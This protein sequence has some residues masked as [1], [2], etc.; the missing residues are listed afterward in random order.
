MFMR[1]VCAALQ[2][3]AVRAGGQKSSPLILFLPSPLFWPQS[4]F[5]LSVLQA[6]RPGSLLQHILRKEAR[7]C[8]VVLSP[9]NRSYFRGAAEGSSGRTESTS[10]SP[11]LISSTCSL[12][13]IQLLSSSWATMRKQ[14]DEFTCLKNIWV[15]VN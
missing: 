4:N 2:Q 10:S 1:C 14:T 9:S 3:A 11:L 6:M 7:N 12:D 5:Y 15:S 13:F 8:F